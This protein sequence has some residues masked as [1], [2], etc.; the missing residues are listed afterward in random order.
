MKRPRHLF[1]KMPISAWEAACDADRAID[2]ILEQAADGMTRVPAYRY[3]DLDS[4]TPLHQDAL[5]ALEQLSL[6]RFDAY[7]EIFLLVAQDGEQAAGSPRADG[8][9]IFRVE[10]KRLCADEVV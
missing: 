4:L 3:F 7:L 1:D 9:D 8:V 5:Y 10:R 6:G 2:A